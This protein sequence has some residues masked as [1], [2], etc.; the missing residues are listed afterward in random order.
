MSGNHDKSFG[1]LVAVA[2][3]IA[4]VGSLLLGSFF[5]G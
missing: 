1:R 2:I 4:I 3:V 5:L